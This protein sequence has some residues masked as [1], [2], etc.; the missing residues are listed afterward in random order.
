MKFDISVI[1][2]PQI[3][4]IIY[5]YMKKVLLKKKGNIR[6]YMDYTKTHILTKMVYR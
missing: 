2:T 5:H 6:K 3:T 1:L 4:I